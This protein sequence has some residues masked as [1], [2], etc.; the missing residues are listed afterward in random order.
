MLAAHFR[1]HLF[2]RDTHLLRF[3]HDWRTVR[4]IRTDEMNF[5]AAHSLV[6]NPDI[7]LDVLEHVAEMDGTICVR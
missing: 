1:D 6:T 3:E 7:C 5:V 2:R 4:V